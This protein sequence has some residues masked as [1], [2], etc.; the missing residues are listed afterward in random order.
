MKFDLEPYSSF[1]ISKAHVKS[2]ERD[3]SNGEPMHGE[4]INKPE[5]FFVSFLCLTLC[6]FSLVSV[7]IDSHLPY[8]VFD[9]MNIKIEWFCKLKYNI[10]ELKKNQHKMEIQRYREKKIPSQKIEKTTN[11]ASFS[12][13]LIPMTDTIHSSFTQKWFE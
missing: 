7:A 10:V 13:H 6:R 1:D 8:V 5:T 4:D 12:L 11:Q 2:I 9:W 3:T